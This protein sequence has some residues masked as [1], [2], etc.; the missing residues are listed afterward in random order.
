MDD[1]SL[2]HEHGVGSSRGIWILEDHEM[3]VEFLMQNWNHHW[4]HQQLQKDLIP[5]IHCFTVPTVQSKVSSS[6]PVE[7]RTLFVK[8]QP[9]VCSSRTPNNSENLLMCGPQPQHQ[10]PLGTQEF[11]LLGPTLD[12]LNQQRCLNES[13]FY[14]LQLRALIGISS[15]HY[16]PLSG[17]CILLG[18]LSK[19]LNY[20]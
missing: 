1:F 7:Y 13:V 16:L 5:G 10:H 14:Y 8:V 17:E 9:Q 12:L 11:K 3:Q 15:N 20:S 2:I 18:Y 4:Y 6:G 19:G